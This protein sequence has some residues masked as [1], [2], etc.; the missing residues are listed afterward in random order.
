M[1]KNPRDRKRDYVIAFVGDEMPQELSK[2]IAENEIL[3]LDGTFGD[4][5]LGEP[6]EYDHVVIEH[7]RGKTEIEFYNKGITLAMGDNEEDKRIFRV[8]VLL[9]QLA[10]T[11]K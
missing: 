1:L 7:D 3:D 10:V 11:G 6:I 9:H 4:P 5:A 8:C 2:A